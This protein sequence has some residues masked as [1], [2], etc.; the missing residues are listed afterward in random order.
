MADTPRGADPLRR[1]AEAMGRNPDHAFSMRNMIHSGLNTT[2]NWLDGTKDPSLVGPAEMVSPL[3]AL[4]MG[5]IGRAA[6]PGARGLGGNKI[7]EVRHSMSPSDRYIEDFLSAKHKELMARQSADVPYPKPPTHD[8]GR[9]AYLHADNAKGSAPG[10]AINSMAEQR[11]RRPLSEW[12]HEARDMIERPAFSGNPTHPMTPEQRAAQ[13]AEWQA[14]SAAI[15]RR[16]QDGIY[17][18]RKVPTLAADNAKGSATGLAANST[19]Q[20]MDAEKK[21]RLLD[22]LMMGSPD[23]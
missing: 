14:E 20:P 18:N 6:T 13:F 8:W 9:G 16:A 19:Q 23:A 2:A 7:A 5:S 12:D 3:G 1:L 11:V 22:A 17:S 21:R 4:P 15:V 10:T